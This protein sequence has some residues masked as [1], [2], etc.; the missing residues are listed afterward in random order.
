MNNKFLIGLV[1]SSTTA[2]LLVAREESASDNKIALGNIVSFHN[3]VFGKDAL[4]KLKDDKL[5]VNID[6]REYERWVQAL[7]TLLNN[8]VTTAPDQKQNAIR[9]QRADAQFKA[10]LDTLK[11][12]DMTDPKIKTALADVTTALKTLTDLH[13]DDKNPLYLAFQFVSSSGEKIQK[14][15]GRL[16][17]IAQ[18]KKLMS[19]DENN[20]IKK[21]SS[22]QSFDTRANEIKKIYNGVSVVSRFK[23]SVVKLKDTLIEVNTNLKGIINKLKLTFASWYTANFI[24]VPKDRSE[25]DKKS[26]DKILSDVTEQVGQSRQKL[27]GINAIVKKYPEF[28]EIYD[29]LDSKFSML[30]QNIA[31]LKVAIRT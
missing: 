30:D 29:F 8:I 12:V 18:G 7:A 31:Q 28:Q 14:E 9:M 27:D 1:L 26:Q 25:Q 16:S 20:V 22:D 19:Y 13:M 23:S 3:A 5:S 4:I 15:L 17:D 21:P 6:Q 10:A 24:S 11:G 2:C